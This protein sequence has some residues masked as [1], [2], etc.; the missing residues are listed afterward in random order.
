MRT[1]QA[2]FE[3]L[4]SLC[5]SKG[6]IHALATICF[7]DTLVRFGDRLSADE[8][9][10]IRSRSRLI[11]TEITTLIGLAMRGPIDFS[12]PEPEDHSLYLQKAET[13][14]AELHRSMLA[15]PEEE[16]KCAGPSDRGSNN[17]ALGRFLREAIFYGSESAYTFQYRDLA[18]Q[19][20]A[21]DA[22][23]LLEKKGVRLEIARSVCKGVA[24]ILGDRL[25]KTLVSLKERSEEE[26]TLLPGFT[27]SCAELASRIDEPV[28]EVRAFVTAFTVPDDECNQ[29]FSSLA[30]FNAAYAFPILRQGNDAFLLLQFYGLSEAVYEAPFYWMCDDASYR[31]T[32]LDHRG[33][34]AESFSAERLA[35]VFGSHRVF[36]NV[37]IYKSKGKTLGEIDV[38]VIFGDR[39]VIVQA[40]SKRLTLEAR[41]GNDGALRDDFKKAVQESVDQAHKCSEWLCDQSVKLRCRDGRQI[42]LPM[43]P[44]TVFPISVVAD[45]YPAL[46]FQARQFLKK[47]SSDRIVS[48]LVADV[49]ALD[50]MSEFLRSPLRFLSYLR[51][52]AHFGEKIMAGHEHMILSYHLKSNLWFE[53]DLDLAM[54]DDDVSSDLDIAMGVRREGMPGNATPDGILTRFEGTPFARILSEI[55]DKEESPAIGLGF[56]LLELGEDAVEKINEGIREMLKRSARD[57][58]SHNMV[59]G[60]SEASTGL[61][62]HCSRDF[63]SSSESRLRQHCEAR[64]YTEK[65][66]SWFGLAMAP[67]GSI[68]LVAELSGEWREDPGLEHV[69]RAWTKQR[70]IRDMGRRKMRRNDPCYCGSGRKYKRC[71]MNR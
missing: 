23:W 69:A 61:T 17:L 37:E 34:F 59:V 4:S 67:T 66:N 60:I 57:G 26:W 14:L 48:P 42:E 21:A 41:K 32:A 29:G 71:C 65:A 47:K 7:R 19:K 12:L 50:A 56:M 54:I 36:K 53:S 45:H 63:D 20:Y 15:L 6:F 22:N 55:E 3:E 28:D 8:L 35:L 5:L 43:R 68:R 11:R 46:A 64:K 18:S 62:V 38:L 40:K 70:S 27:F 9:A 33:H 44:R 24:D 51:V 13:L 58:G 16:R 25:R 2:I 30:A 1:E 52:R 31:S 10:E 49:F 39:V